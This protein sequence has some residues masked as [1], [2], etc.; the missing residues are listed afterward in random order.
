MRHVQHR[1]LWSVRQLDSDSDTCQSRT[2]TIRI[3]T[4]K[5]VAKDL[6]NGFG[7]RGMIQRA[8]PTLATFRVNLLKVLPGRSWGNK[9]SLGTE[10]D[11]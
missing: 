2:A 11:F 1:T 5:P 4:A 8:V 9:R 7:I 6:L 3:G 10:F